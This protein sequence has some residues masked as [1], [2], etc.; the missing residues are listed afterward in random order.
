MILFKIIQFGIVFKIISLTL[1]MK[2]FTLVA[3]Q[4]I[5]NK[6]KFRWENIGNI[7]LNFKVHNH[8]GR[9]L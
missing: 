6:K 9:Q 4:Y 5:L 2:R 1:R 8:A 3:I 7:G